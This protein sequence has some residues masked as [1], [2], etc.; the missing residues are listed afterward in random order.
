MVWRSL[1][2]RVLTCKGAVLDLNPLKFYGAGKSVCC[3]RPHMG[4]L[5]PETGYT[6]QAW[7]DRQK[8]GRTG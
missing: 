8:P 1:Q 5:V 7:G 6:G 2:F 3:L 4:E